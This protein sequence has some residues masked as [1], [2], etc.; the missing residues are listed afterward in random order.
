[1]AR[2]PAIFSFVS[3]SRFESVFV[4]VQKQLVSQFPVLDQDLVE[5]VLL[6]A[7]TSVSSFAMAWAERGKLS[8]SAISPK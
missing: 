1:M 6:I 7:K 3:R 2:K 5:S 4:K 8:I